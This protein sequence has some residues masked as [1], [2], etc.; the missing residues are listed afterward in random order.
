M[1]RKPSKRTV[2]QFL[3]YNLGGFAFFGVGYGVFVLLYGVFSWRW[4]VAKIIADLSGW[5]VNYLI[6]RF[7]AFRHESKH[8]TEKKLLARF[9]I[10]SILNIPIDYAIVGGLKLLGISP[11][12]GLW[13]SSLFFT[14][15]KYVWY[16]LWVFKAP[17]Q[18]VA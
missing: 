2:S 3:V 12:L 16:K 1:V 8:H 10:I 11:F 17:K 5:T 13:I 7:I 15:W 14:V 6:Q 18:P 4:W 9:S